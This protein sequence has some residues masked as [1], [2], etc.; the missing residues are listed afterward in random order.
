MSIVHCTQ[1][2]SPFDASQA[3]KW[4]AA[5]GPDCTI[6]NL[7]PETFRGLP[8]VMVMRNGERVKPEDYEQVLCPGDYVGWSLDPGGPFAVAPVLTSFT[9]VGM[10][11][12]IGTTAAGL[13]FGGMSLGTLG[14][15][16]KSLAAAAFLGN[17]AF[18]VG[19][20]ALLGGLLKQKPPKPGEKD[21]PTYSF[22]G[23][24]SNPDYAG[25]AWPFVF[26]QPRVA[27]PIIN[28]YTDAQSE[29]D[30]YLYVLMMPA[31]HEVTAIGDKT[32]DGGPFTSDDDNLPEGLQINGQPAKNFLD[33][34]CHVRLGT[35]H[36]TTIDGFSSP[37]L[38]FDVGRELRDPDN[39]PTGGAEQDPGV[40]D[41]ED[42]A[43]TA[44]DTPVAI[45]TEDTADA[46]NAIVHF[47]SGLVKIDSAGETQLKTVR[48]QARYRRA[49]NGSPV[50]DYVVLPAFEIS[51]EKTS[52]FSLNYRKDFISP[53]TYVEPTPGHYLDLTP[54][55]NARATTAATTLVTQA[56]AETEMTILCWIKP[57]NVSVASLPFNLVRHLGSN[58]GW[59]FGI[60]Q[61][62][63]TPAGALYEVHFSLT[64]GN[65]TTTTEV[66][67]ASSHLMQSLLNPPDGTHDFTMVAVTYAASVYE[68]GDGEVRFF[69]NGVQTGKVRTPFA[70]LWPITQQVIVGAATAGGASNFD[71]GIDEVLI[72]GRALTQVEISQKWNGGHAPPPAT[73][74]EPDI[75]AGWH[76]DA[77]ITGSVVDD[78]VGSNNLSLLGSAVITD[79][80][81]S[82]YGV[83][84][85]ADEGDLLKDRYLI[86]LQRIT[87]SVESV[88]AQD[89]AEW[90]TLQ[91][92]GY[93]EFEY[94][95]VALL[96]VKM[97]ASDQLSGGMPQITV[98]VKG[99]KAPVW[100]GED[101][102]NP[103]S[104]VTFEWT[105]NPAWCH[106]LAATDLKLGMG[107][108]WTLD[109][110]DW[111]EH[112]E[113]AEYADELL[114][115]GEPTADVYDPPGGSLH[116][117]EVQSAATASGLYPEFATGR[118][119]VSVDSDDWQESWPGG[120]DVAVAEADAQWFYALTGA[121]I[122]ITGSPTWLNN[123]E[124]EPLAVGLV[125]F[126]SVGSGKQR[127]EISLHTPTD[128]GTDATYNPTAGTVSV[129][130]YE[131]RYELDYVA[132]RIDFPGWEGLRSITKTM[133]GEPVKKGGVL[134]IFHDAP[135]DRDN[136]IGMGNTVAQTFATIYSGISDRPNVI[137]AEFLDRQKNH[138]R[139]QI[140]LEHPN[141]VDP[142]QFINRR[143]TQENMEGVTRRSQVMRQLR[144]KLNYFNL[145]R[146][147]YE[148]TG[149]PDMLSLQP[150]SRV[151]VSHDVTQWGYSGRIRED[152]ADGGEVYLDRPVTLVTGQT[153]EVQVYDSG[154]GDLETRTVDSGPGT[155]SP[156]TPL[157]VSS[158]FSFVPKADAK[159]AFGKT[160]KSVM[161]FAIMEMDLDAETLTRSLRGIQYSEA[162]YAD[163]WA[164]L[165][166]PIS[167]LTAPSA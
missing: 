166:D 98:P 149:G 17:L 160:G 69:C 128:P 81:G 22:G 34:E 51:A 21:S 37:V 158:D 85:T 134:S 103:L 105:Q 68:D 102:L 156:G 145:A 143:V 131:R 124:D 121:G 130:R 83:V 144:Y 65:G 54:A 94:P 14:L 58:R 32:E 18:T 41:P 66:E 133:R 80:T 138:E 91:L 4:E 106:V 153:Y 8:D 47:P 38:Q 137:E 26:G 140:V 139:V 157:S 42:S 120:F 59:A 152:S 46:F 107:D 55:T 88:Y 16:A 67:K 20:S 159:Y 45:T 97:R 167:D 25:A 164:E 151:G 100:D 127:F 62:A 116:A 36:Q 165:P 113:A 27:G 117:L 125:E 78:F 13:S 44:W 147:M 79:S 63:V 28:V 108:N 33:I 35:A 72:Y 135:R 39:A 126:L 132:D 29:A 9:G 89:Q 109:D 119:I 11:A 115:A 75:L 146:R 148:A 136:L 76:M 122:G 52:A 90:R 53:D 70:A 1:F 64:M 101:P 93:D 73:A 74:I 7:T 43:I 118:I 162:V 111:A 92:I 110:I 24:S 114:D 2:L 155:Y 163:E 40:Y 5:W 142:T 15:G 71:G 56:A 60:E 49:T 141:V 57:A 84:M 23:I 161:D 154:T 96:A 50:G 6:A 129:R 86:E 112:L 10:G 95:G 3:R 48:F 87:T 123:V 77:T 104:G 61:N 150:G 82:E 19:L 12:G 30:E 99:A 31:G